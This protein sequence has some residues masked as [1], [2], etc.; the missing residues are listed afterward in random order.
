MSL[1]KKINKRLGVTKTE[2]EN[3]EAVNLMKV[4]PKEKVVP[5]VINFVP[6]TTHQADT[7]FV[8][9]DKEYK[10]ILVVVDTASR[11]ADARAMK[12]KTPGTVLTALRSIWR[13]KYL[14]TPK[15]LATDPG[16]E[17]QGAVHQWLNRP[18]VDIKHRVGRVNR[19]RQQSLAEF[20]NYVLGKSI[21]SSQNK[22]ELQTGVSNKDWRKHLPL[23]IEEY[24]KHMKQKK[25]PSKKSLPTLKCRG[26]SC[27]LLQKGTKV[28][29]KLDH[30]RDIS[31]DE[32]LGGKFRAGDIRWS[33]AVRK[34]TKV[35]L[36]PGQPPMYKVGGTKDQGYET[37][38]IDDALYTRE[39]LQVV[40]KD[41]KRVDKSN[42][43]WQI[44]RIV[45]KKNKK[46]RRWYEVQWKTDGFKNTD[47]PV[48]QL[49]KDAPKLVKEFEARKKK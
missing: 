31:S 42:R 34:I 38:G 17:F 49:K 48:T 16:T 30:P 3:S 27:K 13:G 33:E 8:P 40:D 41:E 5:R 45:R 18:R 37:T 6:N 46:G 21:F 29:V 4:P 35:T 23:I 7:L 1:F 39:Q 9:E 32:R 36:K 12:S 44:K 10:Y 26:M 22:K 28:R 19:H 47:V 15:V 24:N 14:K 25:K 43:V 11:I 20:V 2:N